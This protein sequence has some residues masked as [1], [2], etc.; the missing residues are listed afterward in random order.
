M[1]EQVKTKEVFLSNGEFDVEILKRSMG[2]DEIFEVNPL[3]DVKRVDIVKEGNI[4]GFLEISQEW[5][6]GMLQ[7]FPQPYPLE[8]KKKMFGLK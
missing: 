6:Y 8:E 5:E 3:S 7:K 4:V 2:F 1:F